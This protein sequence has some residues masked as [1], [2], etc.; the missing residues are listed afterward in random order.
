MADILT[1]CAADQEATVKAFLTGQGHTY[2]ATYAPFNDDVVSISQYVPPNVNLVG[3]INQQG[4][5]VMVHTR[6]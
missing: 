5:K 2:V 6:A 4:P 3:G 1:I